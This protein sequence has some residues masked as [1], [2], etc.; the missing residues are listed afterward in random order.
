[1]LKSSSVPFLRRFHLIPGPFFPDFRCRSLPPATIHAFARLPTPAVFRVQTPA[2]AVPPAGVPQEPEPGVRSGGFRAP[3]A[4]APSEP[5][6]VRMTGGSGRSVGAAWRHKYL[7]SVLPGPK[8]SPGG[9]GAS[10]PTSS[11]SPAASAA[12]AGPCAAAMPRRRQRSHSAVAGTASRP[13]AIAVP[14]SERPL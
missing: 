11:V 1:M 8:R 12:A 4:A 13:I 10:V 14:H 5:P 2:D 7:H 3:R 9:V 6:A